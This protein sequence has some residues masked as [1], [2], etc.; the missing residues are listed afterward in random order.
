[1]FSM[2]GCAVFAAL[3][4]ALVVFGALAAIGFGQMTSLFG[5]PAPAQGP[6][7]LA[8]A[9][10]LPS[11]VLPSAPV[12]SGGA[13]S[14][15]ASSGPA[16]SGSAPAAAPSQVVPGGTFPPISAR[17]FTSGQA[18]VKVTGMFEVDAIVPL[19]LPASLSDGTMTWMQYGNSG[20]MEPNSLV[21]RSESESGVQVGAQGF[22]AIALDV[23]CRV[24]VEVDV[25][26]LLI[27]GSFECQGITALSPD[28]NLG[29]VDMVVAFVGAS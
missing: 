5:P 13:P 26:G 20:A 4:A 23:D 6:G 16:A 15:P 3:I 25:D 14:G 29:L 9:S 11:G 22:T 1:M 28:G 8:T 2:R 19:N 17:T 12:A 27:E 21:T 7:S 24:D 10:P 18:V